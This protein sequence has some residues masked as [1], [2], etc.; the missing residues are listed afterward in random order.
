MSLNARQEKFINEYLI[1]LNGTQAA[2]RAGYSKKTAQEIAAQNL[3]K[4]SIKKALE[5]KQKI[6]SDET[7]ITQKYVLNNL[8]HVFEYNSKEFD[9]VDMSGNHRSMMKN[10]AVAVKA[11]ELLGKHLGMFADKVEHSLDDKTINILSFADT[12]KIITGEI[13]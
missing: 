3:T 11:I 2:I 6:L 9:Q 4:P 8:K 10:P 1:D 13:V 7:L 5:E 12:Q